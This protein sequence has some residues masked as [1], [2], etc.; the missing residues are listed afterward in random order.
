M[1]DSGLPDVCSYEDDYASN[2]QPGL[3]NF[4]T[5]VLDPLEAQGRGFAH[6]HKKTMG[7]PRTAGAKLRQMFEQ[8]DGALRESVQ[9]ARDELLRCAATIMYDSATLAAEQLGKQV[10]PEPF[11]QKTRF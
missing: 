11:I 3:A 9:C 5:S 7:V 6:G 10:L 4:A 1:N 8:D 2:G